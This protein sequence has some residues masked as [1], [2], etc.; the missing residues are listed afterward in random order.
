MAASRRFWEKYGW[1]CILLVLLL[2]WESAYRLGFFDPAKTSS[3][4]RAMEALLANIYDWNFLKLAATSYFNALSGIFV[5]FLVAMPLG[6]MG[7]AIKKIDLGATPFIMLLGSLPVLALLP[8][9]VLWF[10]YGSLPAIAMA[11]IAAFFPIYFNVREGVMGIP[12][13]LFE[14]T[15]M[16]GAKR[17]QTLHKLV[18]PS[19]WPNLFTGLRLSFQYVWEIILAIEMVASVAGIGTYIRCQA[20][21]ATCGLATA[22][23]NV[24]NALAGVLI[25]GIMIIATDR[26]IFEKFEED[27]AKWKG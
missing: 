18:L 1:L 3:P 24:D 15:R 27:I 9:I 10:G 12:D 22:A 17:L 19:V 6:V 25:V 13:E 4:S 23:A 26:I 21:P 14:A 20:L 16:F 5:A 11:A 8:L 7:G 2:A